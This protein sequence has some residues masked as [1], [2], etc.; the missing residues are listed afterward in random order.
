MKKVI[1]PKG[2]TNKAEARSGV[3]LTKI[4]AENQCDFL[5]SGDE[6]DGGGFDESGEDPDDM[7]DYVYR[8]NNR[9]YGGVKQSKAPQNHGTAFDMETVLQNLGNLTEDQINREKSR[10]TRVT[11]VFHSL[12]GDEE[13]MRSIGFNLYYDLAPDYAFSSA[14]I[15]TRD[16]CYQVLDTQILARNAGIR[17]VGPTISLCP[18]SF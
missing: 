4:T 6:R 7:D 16:E 12:Q 2:R 5:S 3:K 9:G 17:S 14:D 1:V 18:T 15:V 10:P 13:K 11:A 8:R